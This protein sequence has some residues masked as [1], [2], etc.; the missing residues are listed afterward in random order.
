MRYECGMIHLPSIAA[1]RACRIGAKTTR[2]THGEKD[3]DWRKFRLRALPTAGGW[4][5]CLLRGSRVTIIR[6]PRIQRDFTILANSVCL[7]KSLTMRALGV[8][9]RLLCRPD[10]WRTNSESL[11]AEFGCGRDAVRG[12]LQELQQAGY[13]L[14]QKTQNDS[15]HWSSAWLVF[16]EP[17][18]GAGKADAGKADA[19][20]AGAGKA[21][22]GK[23]GPIT[24]TDGIRTDETRTDGASASQKRAATPKKLTVQDLVAEGVD[25]GYAEAWLQVRKEKRLP[26]TAGAWKVT[27]EDGAKCELDAAATVRV[28]LSRGWA[29]FRADWYDKQPA[30]SSGESFR[31]RDERVA[32]ESVRRLT[33]G[34]AHN[35]A[36]VGEAA[37]ELLPFERGY[38]KPVETIEGSADVSR[39]R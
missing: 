26:L 13:I 29:A 33:G 6:S 30:G 15:G 9:V 5:G 35:R 32:A 1:W 21:D 25:E 37:R 23:A 7:D 20:K 8:L 3:D 27:R 12:A 38:V 19:G 11:A 18:A 10:N 31:E 34:L 2:K 36:A 16:E 28:C 14:L 24:R 22:A 17:Q 4:P 39:T